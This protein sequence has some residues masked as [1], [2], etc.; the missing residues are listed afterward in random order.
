MPINLYICNDRHISSR[1]SLQKMSFFSK[2]IWQVEAIERHS[3]ARLFC[4]NS[5]VSFLQ[6][7][8]F[9]TVSSRFLIITLGKKTTISEL[10]WEGVGL[11][12]TYS[13]AERQK[14]REVP[15]PKNLD[16]DK[17]LKPKHSLFCCDIKNCRDLRTFWKTLSKKVLFGSNT[18]FIRQEVHYYIVLRCILY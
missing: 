14:L 12:P 2:N 15:S 17:N 10:A 3:L 13:R 16:L 5:E 6:P 7:R 18:V 9:Q 1:H 11:C 4:D 8:A